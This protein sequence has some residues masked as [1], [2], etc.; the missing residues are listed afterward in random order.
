MIVFHAKR[1]WNDNITVCDCCWQNN[2]FYW[3]RQ[4]STSCHKLLIL[5]SIYLQLNHY[6]I[7]NTNWWS[8]VS[9][10]HLIKYYKILSIWIHLPQIIR[11]TKPFHIKTMLLICTIIF[12]IQII[13]NCSLHKFA[14]TS[15][16]HKIP[17]FAKGHCE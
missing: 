6:Y 10:L 1:G 2:R 15:N 17:L 7:S 4:T 13:Y 12:K 11:R 14:S 3:D 8:G 9:H 5:S 16:N